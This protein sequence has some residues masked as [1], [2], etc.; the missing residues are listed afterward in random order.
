[1]K[2]AELTIVETAGGAVVLL[3]ARN[4]GAVLLAIPAGAAVGQ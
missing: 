4:G 2:P 1:V 3:A